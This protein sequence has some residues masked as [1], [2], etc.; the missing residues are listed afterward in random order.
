MTP[1][2]WVIVLAPLIAELKGLREVIEYAVCQAQEADEA[3]AECSHPLE[4][5]IDFGWTDGKPDWHCRCG[6]RSLATLKVD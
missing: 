5:R 4:R 1:E 6:F 2:D 3:E